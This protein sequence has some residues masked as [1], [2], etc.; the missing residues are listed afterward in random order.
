MPAFVSRGG[1]Y[2]GERHRI[3]AGQAY[4]RPS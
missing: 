2:V 4:V 1:P 3:A